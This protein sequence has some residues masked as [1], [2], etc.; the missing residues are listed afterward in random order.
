[1]GTQRHV[2]RKLLHLLLAEIVSET[3][4]K[5]LP[6]VYVVLHVARPYTV[7]IIPP[8]HFRYSTSAIRVARAHSKIARAS[9]RVD[10]G[11]ATPLI[12]GNTRLYYLY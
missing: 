10:P 7:T 12:L 5:P 4:L 1:M 8:V 3:V 6:G 2:H 9:A 11:L